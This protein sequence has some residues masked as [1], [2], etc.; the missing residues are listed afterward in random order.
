MLKSDSILAIERELFVYFF[1]DPERLRRVID[2][3]S[4]RVS[5]QQIK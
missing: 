2:D 3:V 4:T 1:T 5:A